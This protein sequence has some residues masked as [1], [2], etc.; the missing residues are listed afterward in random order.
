MGR[1]LAK[2]L[3][4]RMSKEDFLAQLKEAW[5]ST[6]HGTDVDKVTEDAKRRI[7]SSGQEDLFKAVGVTDDDL[8]RVVKEIIDER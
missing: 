1:E 7:H 3:A 5:A 6:L 4:K 8:R 2:Q